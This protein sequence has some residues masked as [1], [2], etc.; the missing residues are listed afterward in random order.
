MEIKKIG[1]RGI[2]F[3]LPS[4]PF[5]VQIY[6]IDAPN[7]LFIIDSGVVLENQ[8]KEVKKYLEE[9]RLLTKPIIL[10]HSHHHLD[11][12]GGSHLID[13]IAIIGHSRSSERLQQTIELL[14]QYD[15]YRAEIR[16]LRPPTLT[17]E[18]KLEFVEDGLELFYSPGHTED[19]ISCYD[20]IDKVLFV[21]D[22]LVHPLPSIN[23]YELDVFIETLEKYKKIDFDKLVLGHEKVFQDI[24]FIDVSIEYLKKFKNLEVDFKDFTEVQALMYRWGLV[25]LA[26]NLQ[27]AG[28]NEEAEKFYI[29]AKEDI[30]NPIIKP[31]DEG[32]YE[33]LM[34]E[35]TKGL[36]H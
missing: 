22:T 9:N 32:E 7:Y 28:Y 20:K 12:I 10:I 24:K 8:M 17:F 2:L 23:W 31:T 26:K 5:S 14:E 6:C 15:T 25:N 36:K 30:E 27:R 1:S 33:G 13:S 11:H 34:K 29:K 35:I 4:Q 21:G 3:N 18:N 16:N 19:S